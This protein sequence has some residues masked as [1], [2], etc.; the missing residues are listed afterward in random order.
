MFRLL[1]KII[2]PILKKRGQT[3]ILLVRRRNRR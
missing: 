3:V 1:E 2:S